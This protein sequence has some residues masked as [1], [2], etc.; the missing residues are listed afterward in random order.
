MIEILGSSS[1]DS[2]DGTST[3]VVSTNVDTASRHAILELLTVLRVA[4]SRLV[5]KVELIR[6]IGRLQLERV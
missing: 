3:L 1:V 2:I 6:L 4:L 5:I